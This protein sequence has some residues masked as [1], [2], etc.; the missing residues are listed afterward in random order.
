MKMKHVK[1]FKGDSVCIQYTAIKYNTSLSKCLAHAEIGRHIQIISILQIEAV[2]TYQHCES[3]FCAH[4]YE[5]N[6]NQSKFTLT[7][8]S[9]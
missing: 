4:V 3:T 6:Q 7:S 1:H 9:F 5:V 2:Y 8:N